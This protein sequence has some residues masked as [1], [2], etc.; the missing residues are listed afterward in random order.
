MK[1]FQNESKWFAGHIF[2][3]YSIYLHER[4]ALD[5]IFYHT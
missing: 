3:S 4:H 5:L 1:K 2:I